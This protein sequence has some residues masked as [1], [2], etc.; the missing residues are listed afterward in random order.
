MTRQDLL[1]IRLTFGIKCGLKL[2]VLLQVSWLKL[3]KLQ[4]RYKYAVRRLK[5]RQM[6]IKRKKM[7]EAFASRNVH[8]FWNEVKKINKKSRSCPA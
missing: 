1:R 6:Y 7:G 2:A 4:T 8:N 3:R 5:R